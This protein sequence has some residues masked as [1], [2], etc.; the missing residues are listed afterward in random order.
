MWIVL[1]SCSTLL[2]DLLGIISKHSDM[3]CCTTDEVAARPWPCLLSTPPVLWK[4]LTHLRILLRTGARVPWILLNLLCVCVIDS[5]WPK[6][7]S[8]LPR[9][10]KCHNFQIHEMLLYL[11]QTAFLDIYKTTKQN[12]A[13]LLL[14]NFNM[15]IPWP[16]NDSLQAMKMCHVVSGQP[17]LMLWFDWLKKLC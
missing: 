11:V 17:V 6:D 13:R 1:L 15:R 16:R 7:I 3:V 8:R 12:C 5:D 4:L 2:K 14:G 9:Y 10:C